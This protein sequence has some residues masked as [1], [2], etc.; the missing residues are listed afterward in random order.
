MGFFH[1]NSESEFYSISHFLGCDL[2]MSNGYKGGF[3]CSQGTLVLGYATA[4]ASVW[5]VSVHESFVDCLTMGW[6]KI[7]P[8][9]MECSK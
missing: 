9:S 5:L 4:P 3:A 7:S 2:W 8:M 6:T 1:I